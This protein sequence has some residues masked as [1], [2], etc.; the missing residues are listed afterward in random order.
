MNLLIA[1]FVNALF[2]LYY[3]TGNLG[4]AVILVTVIIRVLLFP[5][6]LPSFKSAQKMRELQPRLKKLQE[7]YAGD[8][9]G[10]A[11]AQMDFYKQE[12]VNPLGGCLPQLAQ[13]AILIIFFSAFNLVTGFS[14]GKK[15]MVEINQQLIPSFQIKDD[16]KFDV[17]F[18]G[19]DLRETP[20]KIFQKGIGIWLVVPLFMLLGSGVLQYLGAKLMLPGGNKLSV[21][22]DQLR[23]KEKEEEK[24]KSDDMQEMMRTQTMYMMP[25][26][27]IF[28]GWS[29]SIGILLYWFVNSAVMTA[30]QVWVNGK[31]N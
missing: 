7:K 30:Q 14:E 9:E 23:I 12:G 11:K 19:S 10:L 4:L 25:L 20:A 17:N 31:K 27:T 5:L 13:V 15:T 2:G 6:V 16:F 8:K 1:P 22:S 18:L 29:F 24:P 26:M 21:T 28:I 3:L